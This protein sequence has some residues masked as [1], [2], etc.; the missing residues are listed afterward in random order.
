MTHS[1]ACPRPGNWI[2]SAS[3]QKPTRRT[4][5]P[6]QRACSREWRVLKSRVLTM[7][8]A[9]LLQSL[10]WLLVGQSCRRAW[11]KI[12]WNNLTAWRFPPST[13]ITSISLWYERGASP[14]PPRP[15]AAVVSLRR[16][17]LS[18]HP[19]LSHEHAASVPTIKGWACT[20]K[21]LTPSI[22]QRSAMWWSR[23]SRTG[24]VLQKTPCFLSLRIINPALFPKRSPTATS[25]RQKA[26]PLWTGGQGVSMDTATS[27]SRGRTV[28]TVPK[29]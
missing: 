21:A 5:S 12:N 26:T 20:W 24:A 28:A 22:S 15:A 18:A 16:A 29:S 8:R 27:P 3:T 10:A 11:M 19:V 9:K 4:P 25:P 13:A 23:T 14:I 2:A 6:K 1:A 17:V 7:A